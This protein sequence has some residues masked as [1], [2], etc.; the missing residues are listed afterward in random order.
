MWISWKHEHTDFA[1]PLTLDQKAD[2]FYEQT[3]GWQL[4]IADLVANGG[5]TL[6]EFK[7]GEEGYSVQCIRHS[8][9]AVLH[10]CLSYV[11]LVGSLIEARRQSP[12]KTFEAGARAIPG[13]IDTSRTTSAVFARLYDGARCGLYHEGRTRPGVGLGEP[14]DGKAIASNP[15]GDGICMS[16]G[17]L[18]QVLKAHLAQ[19]KQQLLDPSNVQL[20]RRFEQRFNA[21]FKREPPN[22]ALQRTSARRRR[23]ARFRR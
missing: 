2:V 11:E 9:F 14:P 10:I 16:P 21:G 23:R 17:R 6:G 7:R 12:T 8:G 13:L 15:Q 18:P 22:N 3:L 5:V 19:L 1:A 4:H 20:R